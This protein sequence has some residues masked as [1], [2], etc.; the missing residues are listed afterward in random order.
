MNLWRARVS[1]LLPY[2]FRIWTSSLSLLLEQE[3]IRHKF[4]LRSSVILL[5]F[6]FLCPRDH[7]H[8]HFLMPAYHFSGCVIFLSLFSFSV[9]SRVILARF[10][11]RY[12]KMRNILNTKK[13]FQPSPLSSFVSC[14]CRRFCLSFF[15]ASSS[16]SQFLIPRKGYISAPL[17]LMPQISM[18]MRR[19]RGEIVWCGNDFHFHLNFKEW[20]WIS[21]GTCQGEGFLLL[22]S[23]CLPC[24]LLPR[25]DPFSTSFITRQKEN[26]NC[27]ELGMERDLRSQ[28]KERERNLS[29]DKIFVYTSNQRVLGPP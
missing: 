24:V 3:T 29:E 15:L 2:F 10:P 6:P 26:V 8:H 20:L 18:W 14:S 9:P 27:H 21:S 22:D 7:H 16:L 23:F 4:V 5:V 12:K 25:N 17:L 13:A 28:Q 19:E 1:F 11:S